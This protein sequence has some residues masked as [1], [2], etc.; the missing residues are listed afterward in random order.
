MLNLDKSKAVEIS[1]MHQED[2][3]AM[4]R[5]SDEKQTQAF[6]CST[7]AC[8]SSHLWSDDVDHVVTFRLYLV[9]MEIN[10]KR[11]F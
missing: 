5:D 7:W 8:T 2:W 1:W 9:H 4:S 6:I 11:K 10:D 3:D